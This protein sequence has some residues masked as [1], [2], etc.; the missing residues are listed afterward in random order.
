MPNNKCVSSSTISHPYSYCIKPTDEMLGDAEANP[1]GFD[2]AIA[3]GAGLVTYATGL[4]TDNSVISEDCN[5]ILGN[6]Y[7]LETGVTCS[8]GEPRHAYINNTGCKNMLSG[9]TSD[10]CGSIPAALSSASKINGTGILNAFAGEATPD[11]VKVKMNCHI[12][13]P[14][15]KSKYSSYNSKGDKTGNND[16]GYVNISKDELA[17]I[18]IY[19]DD[20]IKC[21]K[22][23]SQ[24]NGLN[25][26][27]IPPCNETFTNI[28]EEVN[29]Y[30]KDN[31]N[32][33]NL[34]SKNKKL[35]NEN[36]DN[37]IDAYYVVLSMFL[38]FVVYKL[39]FKK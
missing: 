23:P 13:D 25:L 37:F 18:Q 12:I 22:D 16:S 26:N 5:G 20:A 33:Y 38:L 11:C 10:N 1:Y 27:R 6:K 36:N 2:L 17:D 4:F 30:L 28:Y 15:T 34:D 24:L 29:K 7:V 8:N 21:V 31:P 3:T 39:Q 35:I 9:R 32:A 19:D 14:K